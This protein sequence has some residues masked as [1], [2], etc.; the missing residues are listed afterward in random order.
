MLQEARVDLLDLDMCN[1]TQWYGGR[2]Y[3]TNV[4]AG[5]PH[6]RIDTCQVTPRRAALCAPPAASR[7]RPP[8]GPSSS[9]PF[10]VST[11]TTRLGGDTPQLPLQRTKYH[12]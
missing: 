10:P 6:G 5:Y 3:S 2:I 9:D 11:V 7:R 12:I 4:C 1:S 8:L